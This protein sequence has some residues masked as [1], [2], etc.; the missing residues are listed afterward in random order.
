M[1]RDS[2]GELE[3]AIRLILCEI[4]RHPSV[5]TFYVA[6]SQEHERRD[7]KWEIITKD[8]TLKAANLQRVK[9]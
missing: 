6:G 4:D 1:Q 3:L 7:T 5:E 8:S 2:G 9:K